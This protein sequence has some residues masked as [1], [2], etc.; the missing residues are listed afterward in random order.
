[1]IWQTHDN[2]KFIYLIQWKKKYCS[3]WRHQRV[4]SP[5]DHQYKTNGDALGMTYML[6]L[7][8]VVMYTSNRIVVYSVINLVPRAP[9]RIAPCGRVTKTCLWSPSQGISRAWHL[10]RGWG[11]T[12]QL[13]ENVQ[14]STMIF[15]RNGVKIKSA[16]SE[17]KK[18]SCQHVR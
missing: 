4:C 12:V 15:Q 18:F 10:G 17:S 16:I 13:Y 3:W 9:A 7:L 6:D 5:F 11:E 2:K 1:M 8:P 14:G